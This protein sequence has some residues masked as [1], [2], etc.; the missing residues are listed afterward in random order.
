MEKETKWA[1]DPSHSEIAFKIKHLM[2]THIKGVFRSYDADVR[3]SGS[4]FTTAEIDVWIDPASIDTGDTKRDEHLKGADFFDVA[5]HKQ[6]TFDGGTIERST[7]DSSLELWG[8]LTMKGI[9]KRIKLS[10]E[11]GGLT[12]DPYGNEKAGFTVTGTIS[13][14][15]WELKWNTA[16][17]NGGEMVGEEVIVN[18]EIQLIKINDQEMKMKAESLE[19]E[20]VAV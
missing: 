17:E 8:N 6:I 18:C 11:F 2:I 20:K 12:K 3:T 16:L 15:D 10:L 9:S 1:I 5:N 7:K 14:K 4:D 19:D 13:R